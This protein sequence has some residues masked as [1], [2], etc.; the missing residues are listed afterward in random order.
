MNTVTSQVKSA[1]LCAGQCNFA[2]CRE[3]LR[4]IALAQCHNNKQQKSNL[5]F[6]SVPCL[7]A[8]DVNNALFE[9]FPSL[10]L[11]HGI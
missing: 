9:F 5:V 10:F 2:H 3:L 7:P 1:G 11:G 6:F 8:H 4:D